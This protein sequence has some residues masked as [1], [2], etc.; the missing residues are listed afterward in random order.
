MLGEEGKP[1]QVDVGDERGRR[2]T[3]VGRGQAEGGM[4][5][6]LGPG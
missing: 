5:G 3:E 6:A 1:G 2:T 4:G